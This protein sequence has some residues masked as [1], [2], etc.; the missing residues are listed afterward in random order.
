MENDSHTVGVYSQD[1]QK[2]D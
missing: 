2:F 1:K